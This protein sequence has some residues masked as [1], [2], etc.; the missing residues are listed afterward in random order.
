MQRLTVDA[1]RAESAVTA[2]GLVITGQKLRSGM[3]GVASA[4][5]TSFHQGCEV[6]RQPADQ[7]V[8]AV[9][10]EQLADLRRTDRFT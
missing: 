5:F 1:R 10:V 7:T 9:G 6:A 8:G 3:A 4:E 2:L